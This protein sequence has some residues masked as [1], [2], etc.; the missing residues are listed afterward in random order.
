MK[1]SQELIITEKPSAAKRIA[2]ALADSKVEVKKN[3]GVS[4]YHITRNG[5]N[6]SIVCAVGHLFTVTEKEKSFKYPSYDILWKP[7]YEV[8]K[9]SDYAKKYAK[10]IAAEAK[11]SDSFTIA[12]DFDI[13]GEV[14]GYNALRYLCKQKDAQRM[15]FSTLT[16]PDLEEAYVNKSNTIEWGQALAGETRHF[17]DWMYGINVSRALTLAIKKNNAYATMSSGRVQGPTLKLLVQ[18][19]KEIN[20][21]V[22]KKY[23]QLHLLGDVNSE[24]I[25]AMHEN[26]KFWEEKKVLEILEKT[27]GKNGTIVDTKKKQINQ[28]PPTPFDLT[29]L[30]TESYGVLGIP[31]KKALEVAQTLYSS[32]Y[33]SYPRTSSQQLTPKIGFKKI[34]NSLAKIY[35]KQTSFLLNKSVLKPNDGKKTDPAHPAIYPTGIIPKNLD[36]WNKKLYDLVAKRFFATF[37]DIAIR[38]TTTAKIDVEKEIFVAKGTR[39]IVRGWHELYDPYV[40]L[41]EESIP[42]VKIND[43]VNIKEINKLDKETQPPKRYTQASIIKELEKRNLGT[44]ATRAQI[45]DNLYNRGYLTGKSVQATSLGIKIIETLEKYSPKIVE[46]NLTRSFEEEMN[47]IRSKKIEPKAVLDKAKNDLNEILSD[48]KKNE[49]QVGENLLSAL[50]VARKEQSNHRVL[51]KDSKGREVSVRKGKFGPF[52]QIGTKEGEEKPTFSS[53]P[54][55]VKLDKITLEE[56]LNMFRL[57]RDLGKTIDGEE[58]L[59][60]IGRYGPYVKYGKSF[61]SL[62]KEDDPYTITLERAKVLIEKKKEADKNKFIN[63]YGDIQVLN[64]R[65]GPYIKKGKKNYKIPKKGKKPEELTEADCK[66]IINNSK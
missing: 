33:I 39:T 46:E 12:C 2:S 51:G 18:R 19:E 10:M 32:G 62:E 24:D 23:W 7:V 22:P 34:L 53:L 59:V 11:K 9:N 5:K 30:Q 37:G 63:T 42:D 44:K 45:I 49:M 40:R 29:T 4:V 26:D 3:N 57:P 8:S 58:I 16:K 61:V 41:K 17:L 15:K 65:Y 43:I 48:F 13:E 50:R 27:K 25:E 6:I 54:K 56:A 31:P 38:E 64:G 66:E 47:N 20:A 35:P 1:M 28:Q 21:F 55:D 14:I 36:G 52:V 60:N